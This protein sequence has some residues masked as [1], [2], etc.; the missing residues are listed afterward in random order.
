MKK[1]SIIGAGLAGCTLASLLSGTADVT[2]YEKDHVSGL[3]RDNKHYQ[4][5]VHVFHT[6]DDEVFNFVNNFTTIRPHRTLIKSYVNGEL[7]PWPATKITD[8][9][10][11]EQIEG[12]SKK[13]WLKETPKEAFQ[14]I[15]TSDDGYHFH[16]KYEGIP[17]FQRLFNNLTKFTPI[18]KADVR[19]GD[20]DGVVILT[21]AIDEYFNYIY[22]E[23]PYRGMQAVY[24]ESEIGLD[25]DYIAFSDEKVPF[26]RIVDYSRLGYKDRW[27]AIESATNKAKHY[28]IRD[29]K[30]EEIY[31]RYKKLAESK[32]IYL[33]GRLAT[34]HYLDMDE[35]IRQAID[36]A[37][38]VKGDYEKSYIR[39]T[40]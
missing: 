3:C 12:Y 22:G 1:I 38:K 16:G 25:G 14:R 29:D 5:F 4:E 33:C 15:H 40:T 8:Q 31:N 7:K 2:L 19:H 21:G 6:D 20:L 9:V 24:Y 39:T 26:Q 32:G 18:I 23:L 27:L 30:S 28:P 37:R 36:T 13:Q 34:Y 10:I 11:K 17:D 35:V